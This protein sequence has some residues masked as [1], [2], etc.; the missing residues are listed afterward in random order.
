MSVTYV[1]IG[2]DN[3]NPWCLI[4]SWTL[5][6]KFHSNLDQNTIF[7]ED[8]QFA[9]A[10][11]IMVAIISRPQCDNITNTGTL[12]NVKCGRQT[13]SFVV[14]TALAQPSC[15]G[16]CEDHRS[17]GFI[18]FIFALPEASFCTLCHGHFLYI[19]RRKVRFIKYPV[20]LSCRSMWHC[21]LK[22]WIV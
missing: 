17:M 14:V 9:N 3:L 6:S 2:S 13:A 12:D 19:A 4:V 20:R 18:F 22:L 21:L 1:I 11:C 10:V 8:N 16:Q 15:F 5:R 7:I